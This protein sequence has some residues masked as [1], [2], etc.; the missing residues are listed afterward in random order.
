MIKIIFIL[1]S[2][3]TTDEYDLEREFGRY[4]TL[5][6]IRIVRDPENRSRGF[7]FI[8]FKHMDDAKEADDTSVIN[9]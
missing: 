4:G 9:S 3:Y 7:G 5:D 2:S 8:N 6:N 1:F